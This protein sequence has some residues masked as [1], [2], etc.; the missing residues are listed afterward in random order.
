[1]KAD[2]IFE[3]KDSRDGKTYSAFTINGV[4]WMSENLRYNSKGSWCYESDGKSC[5]EFGRLYNWNDAI[6]VCPNGWHLPNRAEWDSLIVWTGGELK[7]G[8]NLAYNDS[9]PFNIVFGYP[10]N[11][12]GRYSGGGIQASFWSAD[13]YNS[14]TAWVYYFL[15]EKLPLTFSNYFSKNYGMMCRCVKTIADSS[16]ETN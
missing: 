15:K 2:S 7:A 12:N 10:P 9:L 5:K 1:M 6:L 13:E 16:S 4:A 14:S 8:H 11:V 3:F